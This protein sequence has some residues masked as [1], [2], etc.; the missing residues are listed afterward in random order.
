[1]FCSIGPAE[2]LLFFLPLQVR[3][4]VVCEIAERIISRVLIETWETLLLI[5]RLSYF[6]VFI[7]IFAMYCMT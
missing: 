2:V 7:V 5:M 3:E 1:M 4:S 6:A